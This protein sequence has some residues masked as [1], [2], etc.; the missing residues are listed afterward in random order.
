HHHVDR[1]PA[2]PQPDPV[3]PA[4]QV[5]LLVRQAELLHPRLLVAL[6]QLALLGTL[7]RVGG[8]VEP[9]PRVAVCSYKRSR[10]S[11]R[12]LGWT[13]ARRTGPGSPSSAGRGSPMRAPPR[14]ARP[15]AAGRRQSPCPGWSAEST[16]RPANASAAPPRRRG[17]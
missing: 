2:P 6:E 14:R 11:G 13:R 1:H 10:S 3:A 12:S 8:L 5:L 16:C 7:E 15:A 9:M 17:E 4:H